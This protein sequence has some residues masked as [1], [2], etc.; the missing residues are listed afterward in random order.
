M[1]KGL[2]SNPS[3]CVAVQFHVIIPRQIWKFDL[4]IDVIK[5]QFDHNE[6]GNWKYDVGDFELLR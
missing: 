6:L 1:F 2:G 3:E 4:A 5:L